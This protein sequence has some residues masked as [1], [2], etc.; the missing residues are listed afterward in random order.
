MRMENIRN[1]DVVI[2]LGIILLA[3]VVRFAAI[4]NIPGNG[5]LNQDEAYAAY[6]AWALSHYGVDS[7]GYANP[8]YFVAWGSG[9]NVLESYIMIPFIRVL[10]LN[11]LSIRLPSAL[12]GLILVVAFY[13]FLKNGDTRKRL[14]IIGLFSIAVIPWGIMISRWA[15]E[16]NYLPVMLLLGSAFLVKSRKKQQFIVLSAMFY[17]LS[18]YAYSATW[19]VMPFFLVTLLIYMFMSRGLSINRWFVSG[20]VIFIIMALPLFLFLLVNYGYIDAIETGFFSVPKLPHFRNDNVSLADGWENLKTLFRILIYQQDGENHN[21]VYHS[22]IYYWIS[23]P[24]MVIGIVLTVIRVVRRHHSDADIVMLVQFICG[25]ILGTLISVNINRV[26]MIHVPIIYFISTG[27]WKT[28]D[29]FEKKGKGFT[30][31]VIVTAYLFSFVFFIREYVTEYNSSF[32]KTFG[33]GLKDAIEFA[34]KEDFEQIHIMDA[35]YPNVL[36]YLEYDPN[37]FL[38]TVEWVDPY[39]S[40]REPMRIGMLYFEEYQNEEVQENACYICD[41]SNEEGEKYIELNCV[42]KKEFGNYILGVR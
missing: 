1:K 16:S 15:L 3:A 14:P 41:K 7:E 24:F 13:I 37:V 35:A 18:L 21:S 12:F 28:V 19:V 34:Q 8:V 40:F 23:I 20:A 38:S 25:I 36:L 32:A 31:L 9:M 4:S 29:L 26:N 10:G 42:E 2:L 27:I 11:N 6:E 30:L 33:E 17:G 5:A 22:G 39:D